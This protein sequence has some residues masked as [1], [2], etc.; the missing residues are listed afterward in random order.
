MALLDLFWNRE[1]K[2]VYG[3]LAEYESPDALLEA[4]KKV[5]EAGYK[6]T[7]SFS[8]FPI[9]GMETALG[10]PDS[11]VGKLAIFFSFTG[12]M[13]ALLMQW[14]TGA[15][16][17]PLVIGGK[18][19]FAFEPS[20]PITFELTVAFSAFSSV[21]LMFFLNGMPRFN[22][23]LFGAKL[24]ERVGDDKFVL[25]IERADPKFNVEATRKLLES[26]SPL[27]TEL[28]EVQA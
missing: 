25:L 11:R 9:H 27:R 4:C 17:Y 1:A 18:P 28:V 22:H 8:P 16:G 21:A 24:M 20:I 7:D 12:A 23:P 10:I 3:L 13:I 26:T 6:K 19:F 15:V 14:W 5:H 2:G